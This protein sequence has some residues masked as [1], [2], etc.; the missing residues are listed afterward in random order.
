MEHENNEEDDATT[1]TTGVAAVADADNSIISNAFPP[2]Y[3]YV[4]R[5]KCN[6]NIPIC[7]KKKKRESF[8]RVCIVFIIRTESN[9]VRVSM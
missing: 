6:E 3:N 9:C 5:R 7:E 8:R 1:T 2:Q 4:R